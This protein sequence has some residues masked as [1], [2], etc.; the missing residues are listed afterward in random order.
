M[1]LQET[2]FFRWY[3][4]NFLETEKR[5]LIAAA[6][7]TTSGYCRGDWQDGDDAYYKPH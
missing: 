1:A 6:A 2:S 4:R 3:N 7:A 5:D